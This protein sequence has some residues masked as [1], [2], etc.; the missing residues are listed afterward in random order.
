[1]PIRRRHRPVGGVWGIVCAGD[2]QWI[3]SYW[4]LRYIDSRYYRLHVMAATFPGAVGLDVDTNQIDKPIFLDLT[5]A[6]AWFQRPQEQDHCCDQA[7]AV[8]T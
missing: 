1:M 4:H 2:S 5:H 7:S 8:F 3:D 6:E